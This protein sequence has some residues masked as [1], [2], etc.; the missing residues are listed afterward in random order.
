VCNVL[1]AANFYPFF[2]SWVFEQCEI[3]PCFRHFGGKR[4]PFLQSSY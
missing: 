4:Y 2:F 1:R 3:W